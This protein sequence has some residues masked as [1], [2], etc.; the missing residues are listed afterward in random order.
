M[1]GTFVRIV[2][3]AAVC[4]V[5]PLAAQDRH[6]RSGDLDR[7]PPE[8]LPQSVL[9][10]RGRN[11]FIFLDN[12]DI[13]REPPGAGLTPV[14]P[15]FKGR[16][17]FIVF[18]EISS[19]S[20]E[21]PPYKG[22]NRF[23][24]L[25]NSD[26]KHESRV[27]HEQEESELVVP[28]QDNDFFRPGVIFEK[29]VVRKQ[30]KT[31]SDV[32]EDV[33]GVPTEYPRDENRVN[34]K[35]RD[36]KIP[37][38]LEEGRTTFNR[39][40]ILSYF[41]NLRHKV[42]SAA[43]ENDLKNRQMRTG[44]YSGNNMRHVVFD[45]DDEEESMALQRKIEMSTEFFLVPS[46]STPL[47]TSSSASGVHIT[48]TIFQSD[49][50]KIAGVFRNEVWVIPVLALSAITMI[51]IAGFEVFVLCKAWRTTPSRRHL[52]LG[53]M[54]LL[55]LFS[56]AGLAS[57]CAASPSQFTCA[58]MRFGTGVAYTIVFAS[59]LVK[60]VFLISLNGGV[61]LPAPYQGLLL[62]FAIL[63]QVAIAVQWLLTSP[64]Q[65]DFVT[66]EHVVYQNR[67]RLLVTAADIST[68]QSI[69]LC[70]TPYVD[71]L[72]SLIYVIFLIVFV[73]VLA[74][75]SRGIRDNYREATY[76]GLSVG[77]S[78]PIWLIW[79]VSGLVVGER[80]R[81]ACIAFGLVVMAIMVFLIMFMPKGRQLAAMGKEGVYVEDREERFSSLSR[82]GSGYSPSFFHFKPIKQGL[83]HGTTHKHQHI[84][85]LGGGGLYLRPDDGNL[86]T[87]LEPTLS[88]N[89]NVYF[90]R[91]N[92]LHPGMMY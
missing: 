8:V 53:Q 71:I 51:L 4:V 89:P 14:L 52:F 50:N 28:S 27:F 72:L 1:A 87:T 81:D 56:C 38:D 54:L 85:T 84:T 5:L 24:F 41:Q 6:A 26:S 83:S 82:A 40:E 47:V 15:S 86:Y 46:T 91:G 79:T 13:K 31:P 37:A 10:F 2:T 70:R 69:P 7:G 33:D 64:P 20:T 9:P 17:K 55:G 16:N 19:P 90:Q 92:G 25:D 39:S 67:N 48:K 45:R 76:I 62:M 22:K 63:I 11:K 36:L 61:Y 34:Q 42:P 44:Q 57:I 66:V 74:V 29:P 18:E 35:R 43:P 73:T 49:E 88:S 65:I 58:L 30:L 80:H 21:V 60:C 23:V 3:L 32:Y 78:I 12:G 68:S 75:K 59:L 77:C